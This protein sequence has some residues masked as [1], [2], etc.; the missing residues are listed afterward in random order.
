MEKSRLLQQQQPNKPKTATQIRN[1]PYKTTRKS[2]C[3]HRI[4]QQQQPERKSIFRSSAGH[5][6]G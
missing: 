1:K 5:H 4:N 3:A 6:C 2:A